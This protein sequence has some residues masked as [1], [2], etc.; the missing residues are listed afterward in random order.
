MMFPP[1]YKQCLKCNGTLEF[2]YTKGNMEHYHGSC[3]KSYT[4]L[5]LDR[6]DDK[7]KMNEVYGYGVA[8]KD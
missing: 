6:L 4:K 3:G 8:I 1:K 7:E 2:L 5:I